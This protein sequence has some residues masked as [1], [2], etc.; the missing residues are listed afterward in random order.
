M[1]RRDFL[2]LRNTPG[3]IVATLDA[4]ALY[5]R[6]LDAALTHRV[7]DEGEYHAI[8][9]EAN[10][11]EQTAAALRQQLLD[12]NAVVLVDSEWL[13]D[14]DLNRLVDQVLDEVRA[15]GGRIERRRSITSIS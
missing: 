1:N 10:W 6:S 13:G 7:D 2:L 11:V 9:G 8:D 14:G 4:Q 5:M 15:R 3:E 12:A